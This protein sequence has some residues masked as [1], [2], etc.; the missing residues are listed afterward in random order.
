MCLCGQT[1]VTQ[2][3]AAECCL[4]HGQLHAMSLMDGEL[5]PLIQG[6]PGTWLAKGEECPICAST[7]GGWVCSGDSCHVLPCCPEVCM[8]GGNVADT[9]VRAFCVHGGDAKQGELSKVLAHLRSHHK[10]TEAVFSHIARSHKH[11]PQVG[12]TGGGFEQLLPV[13]CPPAGMER[14]VQAWRTLRSQISPQ[15]LA[16]IFASSGSLYALED[17]RKRVLRDTQANLSAPQWTPGAPAPGHVYR[18]PAGLHATSRLRKLEAAAF[19]VTTIWTGLDNKEYAACI[20]MKPH[21]ACAAHKS[22]LAHPC[23]RAVAHVREILPLHAFAQPGA[24]RALLT[25][26][27]AEPQLK[28]DSSTCCYWLRSFPGE[29]LSESTTDSVGSPGTS[30]AEE[31]TGWHDLLQEEWTCSFEDCK[32]WLSLF[33]SKLIWP[34]SSDGKYMEATS[35]KC[36][37]DDC[38]GHLAVKGFD[39]W[40]TLGVAED[41]LFRVQSVQLR[42]RSRKSCSFTVRSTD[43]Q[44]FHLLPDQWKPRVWW[45]RIGYQLYSQAAFDLLYQ[46]VRDHF[47]M[48]QARVA[49][50]RK[51]ATAISTCTQRAGLS[52]PES[53]SKLLLFV[54]H[55]E[56]PSEDTLR[57]HMLVA[58]QTL[59]RPHVEFLIQKLVAVFGWIFVFDGSGTPLRH[60]QK[61]PG[62]RRSQKAAKPAVIKSLKKKDTPWTR[63]LRHIL[64]LRLRSLSAKRRKGAAILCV[65]A[66]DVPL[67]PHVMED[68]E[69]QLHIAA[70][71]AYLTHLLKQSHPDA[72]PLAWIDDCTER[73]WRRS[74]RA[75]MHI[76]V[77]AS[78]LLFASCPFQMRSSMPASVVMITSSPPNTFFDKPGA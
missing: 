68:E 15:W 17:A 22:S 59:E 77:S 20:L 36:P 9:R 51:I 23:Y 4:R 75:L 45:D 27:L 28:K 73:S 34:V 7:D 58:F 11:A 78:E 1:Y 46:E 30:H 66:F 39:T 14:R 19:L 26:K 56:L 50:G 70:I 12:V 8:D 40:K 74:V 41:C 54:L 21:C 63:F 72:A 37:R 57:N 6:I 52:I 60:V 43:P 55:H 25:P 3:V 67:L 16:H 76:L 38:E 48:S 64:R 24:E 2:M 53:L 33:A 42:C 65:G 47:N 61:Y 49:L 29:S 69:N 35:L 44:F 13:V 5:H 71:G 10:A 31:M 18:L 32:I 62:R